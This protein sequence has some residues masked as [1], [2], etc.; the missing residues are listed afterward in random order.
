MIT[1]VHVHLVRA[2]LQSPGYLTALGGAIGR[3]IDK[4]KQDGLAAGIDHRKD[5]KSLV[6]V[7]SYNPFTEA[8][9]VSAINALRVLDFPLLTQLESKKYASMADIMDLLRLEGAAAETLKASQPQ[10]FLEQLMLPIHQLEYKV[11]TEDTSF[12]FS[13]DVAHALL[14]DYEVLG[15]RPSGEV[16]SPSKIVFEKEEL[17]TTSEHTMYFSIFALLLASL[18]AACSLLSSSRSRLISKASSFCA[19]SLSTVLNVGMPISTGMIAYVTYISKNGVYPLLDLILM[20]TSLIT[21]YHLALR[22]WLLLFPFLLGVSLLRAFLFSLLGTCLT[23][24]FLKLFASVLTF[25][26]IELEPQRMVNFIPSGFVSIRPAPEQSTTCLIGWSM[27]TMIGC[28]WKYLF[29]RLLRTANEIIWH[30]FCFPFGHQDCTYGFFCCCEVDNELLFFRRS[31]QCRSGFYADL[32]RNLLRL[33]NFPLNFC[34]SFRHLEDGRV[35]CH[36]GNWSNGF[37][38]EVQALIRRIFLVGIKSLHEVTAV[39]VRVNAA[40][41]NLVLFRVIESGNAPLITQVIKDVKTT[42]APT[43]EEKAQKRLELKV[44]STLLMGIPNK[45]Q[46]KFNSIKDAKSLLQAV[47]KRFGGNAANKKTQR[48]LLKHQLDIHGE[49]ISQEDVNQKF[50]RSLSLEWNTH[51]IVWRNKPEIDTLSLDD[52]YNNLKI[53]KPEDLQQIYPDDSEKMDLRWQMAM[54]I[55]RAMRFLKNNERKFS[56]NDNETIRFDKYKVECYNYHKRGHFSKEC[57]APRSQDSK[58]KESTRKAVHVE[59]PASLAL[60]SCDGLG[61]Y[62]WSDQAKEGP[63]NFVLMAYSSTSSNFKV[64]TNSNCLSSCLENVKILKEHNEQLLKDLRTFKINAITYQTCLESVESL[65]GSGNLL[66]NKK[67]KIQLTVEN[68]ENLSKNLSKLIDCQIVDKCKTGLGYNVVPPP[69]TGN[70][71]HPKPNLFGLEEFVNEFIVT[72]PTVKKPVVKTSEAKASADK[73]KVGNP[74]IDLQDKG[75]IDSGCSRNMTWNM[76]YHTDYKEINRAYVAFGGNLKEGKITGREVVNTA[77]YVQYRVLVVKPHNKTPYKFFHGKTPALSFM[78]PFGCPV[79]ILNTKDHLDKF[80]GKADEGFFVRYTLNSKAFRVFNNKTMIVQEN[81]HIRFSDNTPNIAGSRPNWLFDID[82]LTKSM[83]YK[84]VVAGNQSD[85]NAGT[86]AC[87][88]ACKARMVDEDPRQ[89]SECKDQEKED[90]V[91]NTNSVNDVDTNRVNAIGFEDPDF[92]DK[93]YKVEKALYG[94]HQAPRAWFSKVK[95]ASTPMETQKPLLKDED[96]EKVDVHMYRSMIDLLM[97]LTSLRPDI[98]FAVCACARCQVNPKVSHLHV[99]KRI[100]RETPLFPTMMVQAQEEMGEGLTNPIDPHHTP[101]IIQPSISQPQ[102]TKQHRKSR[103]KVTEVPQPSDPTKHVVDEAVNEEMDDNLEI[104]ATTATNLDV[105]QD[106]GNFFKNQSK[107]TPNE[108]GSQGTSSGVNTP[109]S[110]EDSLK[111]NELMELC[112]KLQQRVGLLARVEPSKD[113]GLGEEDASK[114]GRIADIDANEDI[115]LVSTHDEQMFDADQDLGGEEVFVAQ[116]DEKVFEKEVDAAQ[117][118]VTT[119]A[120]TYTISIDEVTLAQALAELK[121]TK[122]KAKDKRNDNGKAKMIEEPMKLKKKDQIQLDEEVALKL[123]AELQAEF[124]KE[125][126]LAR[127]RAQQEVEANIA[128]IESW[129]DVQVKINADY[130]LSERLLAEEQQELNDEEKAKLFM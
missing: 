10:P 72:E 11:V 84:P 106:R 21:V 125:Q 9:Y 104:A 92:L 129:D 66:K 49:R 77:C 12:A 69:Y 38:C 115:T 95:N 20:R 51:T 40:K 61:G 6:D 22:R 122:P 39:K 119:T 88:D 42:I 28:A 48:N 109:R 14:A 26:S 24:N 43:T 34:T 98:M 93:V 44:R 100:F 60:V 130:Q 85:G 82:T 16:P 81:L 112:T 5:G 62:D 76:S 63:T 123:Q 97:Y 99:V 36:I 35:I 33:A 50:L 29:S 128:L 116:Q 114:Q 18:I 118:Q 111:L 127:E 2:C 68:F 126:R 46:L 103:R 13:L 80:D 32:N 107:V 27:M 90:N 105:K 3:S 65:R 52:L 70:F 57:R 30:L 124:D 102:K 25:S 64:S 58:H 91:N 1:S 8:N 59:T 53:Y 15:T 56:M 75:V 73:P 23:E 7:V 83:N 108:P 110:G 87:D 19:M 55:M 4:G 17:E 121:H 74:Q 54:L 113:K 120:T 45:H 67:D 101:T 94:L 96:G 89:E 117:I 37:S 79:T 86:N 31:S 47:E 78:R 41:L 71:L